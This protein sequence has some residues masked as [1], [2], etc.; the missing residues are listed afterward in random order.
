[1]RLLDPTDNHAYP[2]AVV[3]EKPAGDEPRVQRTAAFA[4][5]LAAGIALP[6]SRLMANAAARR[7]GEG[8]GG[9]QRFE[10]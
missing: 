2:T 1:M 6:S 4:P 8:P 7:R 5:P 3:R 10:A 9:K